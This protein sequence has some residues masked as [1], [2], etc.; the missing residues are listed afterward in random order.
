MNTF[1][2]RFCTRCFFVHCIVCIPGMSLCLDYF[3]PGCSAHCT[4]IGR[5]SGFRTRCFRCHLSFIPAVSLRRDLSCTILFY[6]ITDTAMNTFTSCFCTCCFFVHCIVCIPGMALCRDLFRPGCSAHCTGIGLFAGCRTRCFRC[7]LSFIPAMTLRL[8]FS[9]TILFYSIADTAMN[10]FTSCFCTHCF[11]VYCIVCIPGMSLCLDYFRPGCSA[12]CTSIG[13]FSSFRTRCFRCHLS[14]IP[15]MTLGRYLPCTILFYFITDTAMNTFTSCFC[16][17]CFFVHRIVCIPGMSLCLDDFRS[18]CS[19]HCTGIGLFA[20]FRARCLRCHLSS[21][22]AVSLRRYLSCTILFYLITNTAMNTFTSCF[23]TR[24]FFIHCIVCIPGMTLG[25][26]LFRPGCSAHCTSIG[27]FAGFRTRCFRCHFSF[28][29]AMAL[30]RDLSCTI[31]FYL[32]TDTTMN[33]FIS[34]FCAGRLFIYR[35]IFIPDMITDIHFKFL[36]IFFCI[37]LRCRI[38]KTIDSL[39]RKCILTIRN[40]TFLINHNCRSQSFTIIKRIQPNVLHIF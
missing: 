19:A 23:C 28:I 15:A 10:T 16:T 38:F 8:D 7:H 40:R 37:F 26:D 9:F 29:P 14:F 34:G 30:G 11:F 18:G 31:L 35:I 6:C 1:T 3:R 36:V 39:K 20:F 32:I 25:R 21:I 33:T 22:P 13:R 4:S 2:S 24:Y 27:R 17:R 5:F 12:H